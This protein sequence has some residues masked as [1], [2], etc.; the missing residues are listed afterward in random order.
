VAGAT[1]L[2]SIGVLAWNSAADIDSCLASVRALDHHPIELLVGDNASTDDTRERIAAATAPAERVFFDANRGFAGGHNAL[3]A[4][5][6][7]AFYLSLNPDVVLDPGYVG[8]L[9]AAL[10]PRPHVGS[11]TGRL[12]RREPPGVLD[13]TGIV[14]LRSQRHLDRGAGEPDDGRYGTV[15]EVFGASGA[16][17]LYRREMLEDTRVLGECFDE[18]FFA[19]REDADLAWRARLL[20][21]G[22]LYVPRARAWHG[23]RVTPE[24][25]G[26]LPADVNRYSVRNRFLLRIKNQPA[27]HALRFLLPALGRDLLVL[28]YVLLRERSSLPALADVVRLLPRTWRKRRAIMRRRVLSSRDLG[29]WFVRG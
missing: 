16:A 15:E 29:R 12:L 23:R 2:V 5:S 4:R 8:G 18:D 27:G 14:M 13:S 9:V 1:P 19:Y 28:G 22:C 17:A 11:A 25:R 21:W 7:G 26:R 6:S 3:I 10:A 24:R 20:G